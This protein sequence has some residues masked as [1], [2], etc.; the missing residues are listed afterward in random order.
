MKIFTP[1][2]TE[3]ITVTAVE[4][5]EDG[6]AISGTIMGAMPMKG[7]LRPG[8]MRAGFRFASLKLIFTLIAMLFRK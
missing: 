3:L 4:S 1:E 7:V 6:I 2:G 8:E 5:F